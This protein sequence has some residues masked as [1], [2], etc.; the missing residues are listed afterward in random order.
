MGGGTP[1][2]LAT[3]AGSL[4]GIATAA[5]HA[6]LSQAV[7]PV[8]GVVAAPRQIRIT[9]TESIEPAFSGPELADAAGQPIRTGPATVDPGNNTPL[10]LPPPP[11]A[12]GPHNVHWHV[13][14]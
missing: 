12:P 1:G 13:V 9:F 11:P 5:A 3:A 14:S 8:G 2:G 7:P 10:V 4:Y 6:F